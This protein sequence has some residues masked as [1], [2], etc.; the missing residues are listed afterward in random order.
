MGAVRPWVL[1][2]CTL[3][4]SVCLLLLLLLVVVVVAE[5]GSTAFRAG[6][7]G[8]GMPANLAP[9]LGS[10]GG[11]AAHACG[12]GGGGMDTYGNRNMPATPIAPPHP[13]MAADAA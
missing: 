12:T 10:G 5:G 13:S 7:G 2:A 1:C 3:V 9:T 4:L 8:S 6:R 11:N